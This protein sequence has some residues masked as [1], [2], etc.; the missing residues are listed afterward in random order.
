MKD[1]K[2]KIG[3]CQFQPKLFD[4]EHNLK[5]MEKMLSGIKADLIVLPELATCGYVFNR[6]EEVKKVSESAENGPTGKLFRE[7]ASDNNCSYV[8]GFAEIDDGKLFNSCMLINPDGNIFVY[9]KIH[10]FCEEK[11]WFEVGNLG[12]NVF[13]AKNGIKLGL[14][15]CFDWIFPEAARSLSLKD[16]QIIAHPS[17]LV[18]PFCQQ[19]MITR[20]IENQ[21]FTI[22][23]NRT[24]LEKNGEKELHFTGMSQVVSNKGELLKRLNEDEETIFITEI[25]PQFADNKNIT[26]WNNV[27]TDRIPEYYG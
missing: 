2:Y 13:N 19:A 1:Q 21:V 17:N 6:I 15:V 9:R 26:E 7:L 27:I 4:I 11:K 8:V 10:L 12:F 23:T 25:V 20:S 14:M 18:L 22:T 3:V 5:K 16:A 24:G